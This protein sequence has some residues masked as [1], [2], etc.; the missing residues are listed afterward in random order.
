MFSHDKKHVYRKKYKNG[1]AENSCIRFG[2]GLNPT[3]ETVYLLDTDM[4]IPVMGRL[5]VE[6]GHI[7]D[8]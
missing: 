4:V 5:T 1:K 2:L 7:Q 6:Y 3:V 8:T